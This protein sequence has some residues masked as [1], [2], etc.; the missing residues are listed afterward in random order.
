MIA[1]CVQS[2]KRPSQEIISFPHQSLRHRYP[3]RDSLGLIAERLQQIS[4]HGFEENLI[5]DRHVFLPFRRVSGDDLGSWRPSPLRTNKAW[6][7]VP[8]SH[9]CGAQNC[10]TERLADK[11]TY[12]VHRIYRMAK[13]R[14]IG[15]FQ[16]G[17]V[18]QRRAGLTTR[19]YQRL[20][21]A[22]R[23][24]KIAWPESDSQPR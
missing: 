8:E 13:K 22:C 3:A 2:N 9:R 11:L 17:L 16:I 23:S 7:A 12:M 18:R 1:L 4:S 10:F 24:K 15:H 21:V 5:R 6:V 19:A 20:P 14:F